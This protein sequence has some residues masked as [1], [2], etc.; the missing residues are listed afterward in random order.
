M[1]LHVI[2]GDVDLVTVLVHQHGVTMRE[3]G[4]AN[5]LATDTNIVTLETVDN[6]GILYTYTGWRQIS[7]IMSRKEM[8]LIE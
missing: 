1:Y 8:N 7:E 3:G 4:A 6:Q 2:E 5:I